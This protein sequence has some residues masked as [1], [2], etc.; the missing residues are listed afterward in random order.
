MESQ[1]VRMYVSSQATSVFSVEHYLA[2]QFYSACQI[3]FLH[4]F[5]ERTVPDK[6]QYFFYK[7]KTVSSLGSVT[8]PLLHTSKDDLGFKH[9]SP[10]FSSSKDVAHMDMHLMATVSLQ[11]RA[12]YALTYSSGKF[13]QFPAH[14]PQ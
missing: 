14:Q 5:P 3:D 10:W 4:E 12:R 8:F 6:P 11:N 1:G 9:Q 2:S 13:N 7:I